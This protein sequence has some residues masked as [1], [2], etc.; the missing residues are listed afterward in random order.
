MAYTRRKVLTLI[1]G[2][3]AGSAG[4]YASFQGRNQGV[5]TERVPE[6]QRLRWR[7]RADGRVG[8][9]V[10]SRY[11]HLYAGSADNHLYALAPAD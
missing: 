2:G 9:A 4:C 7:Y 11:G 8:T 3:V 6:P 10:R 5:E 1:A